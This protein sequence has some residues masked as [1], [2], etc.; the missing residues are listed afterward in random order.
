MTATRLPEMFTSS[1]HNDEWATIPLNLS[2]F[3]HSGKCCLNDVPV[4]GIN[5]LQRKV[6]LSLVCTSQC[7][8]E[9]S[10]DALVT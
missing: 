5:H 6:L 10:K 3:L 8:E 4:A 7:E 1:G 9:S 2:R